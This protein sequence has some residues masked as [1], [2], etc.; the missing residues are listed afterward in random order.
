MPRPTSTK[1]VPKTAWDGDL[2]EMPPSTW[3][4]SLL[5]LC[6]VSLWGQCTPTQF[7]AN[8]LCS[9][10]FLLKIFTLSFIVF[11]PPS[12]HHSRCPHCGCRGRRRVWQLFDVQQWGSQVPC[13]LQDP[14]CL[15]WWW[16]PVDS[17][18]CVQFN[19][20]IH[21]PRSFVVQNLLT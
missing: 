21:I 19:H 2:S 18:S 13:R 17:A 20:S 5:D 12:S 7:R 9:I 14:Q 10:H 8:T 3:P 6:P 15:W 4:H 11:F 16:V 1:S